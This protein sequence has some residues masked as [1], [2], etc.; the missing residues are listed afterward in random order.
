MWIHVF[1][2]RNNQN[3][4]NASFSVQA[5]NRGDG[6]YYMYINANQDFLVWAPGYTTIGGNTDSWGEMWASLCPQPPP[7]PPPSTYGNCWSG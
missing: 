7:P 2:C 4:T 1:D 6:W 3:I 5:Y